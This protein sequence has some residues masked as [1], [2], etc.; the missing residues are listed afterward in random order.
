[1]Q[2][3]RKNLIEYFKKNTE[4][5]YSLDSLKW[6]LIEQ[7]YSR[8]EVSR[9]IE[10]FKKTLKAKEDKKE[11]PK[12]KYEIYGENNKPIKLKVSWWKRIL[13]LQ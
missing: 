4:K 13:G 5:G 9:A 2:K 7:G 6:A 12:I 1:M 8:I 10:E 11:K 3:D